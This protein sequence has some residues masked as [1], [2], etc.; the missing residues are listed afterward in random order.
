MNN[1]NIKGLASYLNLKNKL[2]EGATIKKCTISGWA[3]DGGLEFKT[4]KG[5]PKKIPAEVIIAA[6]HLNSCKNKIDPR[7][8]NVAWLYMCGHD[9]P[10]FISVLK[11]ITSKYI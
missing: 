9:N 10:C 3:D 2:K 1:Y 4:G 11:H 8:I 6:Y 5:K 7:T